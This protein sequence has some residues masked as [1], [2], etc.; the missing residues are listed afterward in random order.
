MHSKPFTIKDFEKKILIELRNYTVVNFK[1][2]HIVNNEDLIKW[3]A[4]PPIVFFGY[5]AGGSNK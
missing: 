1:I 3:D 5:N 4:S 2:D